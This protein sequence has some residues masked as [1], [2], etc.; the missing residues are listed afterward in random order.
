MVQTKE[1]QLKEIEYQ[2]QM[3]NNLKRWIR[4]LIMLSSLGV[5]GAY[6]T[7][8]VK[9]GM[10]FHLLGIASI[11]FL[12]ICVI[13]CAVIGLAIKNGKSNIEKIKRI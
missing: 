9:E 11:V 8:Q 13:L 3:L 5:L 12:V 4:N 1:E 7:L 10:V 2:S 6:W